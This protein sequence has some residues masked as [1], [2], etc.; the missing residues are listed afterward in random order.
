MGRIFDILGQG[1]AYLLF[2]LFVGYF[3]NSPPYSPLEKDQALV[4]LSISYPG[5]RIA[6]CRKLSAKELRAKAHNMRK[7]FDCPRERHA[8]R[9]EVLMDGKPL[10]DGIVSPSGLAN[11]GKSL[12]YENFPVPAGEHTLMARLYDNGANKKAGF[13]GERA[14]QLAPGK[15]AIV[16]FDHRDH[17]IMIK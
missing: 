12:F 4:R 5:Q 16:G 14:V 13:Q 8:V 7:A 1:V 3:A 9:I 15:V 11:D 10:Y 6:E 17:K 2:A